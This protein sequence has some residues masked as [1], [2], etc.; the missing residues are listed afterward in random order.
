V[1][2]TILPSLLSEG[3]VSDTHVYRAVL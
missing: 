1:S 2:V 3:I